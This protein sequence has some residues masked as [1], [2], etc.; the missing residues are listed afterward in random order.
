MTAKRQPPRHL[1]SRRMVRRS[2]D[3]NVFLSKKWGPWSFTITRWA[4][5]Q[6]RPIEARIVVG[7]EVIDWRWFVHEATALRWLEKSIRAQYE[8]LR[9]LVEDY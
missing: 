2:R 6:K 9:Y 7:A 4:N 5:H 3:G 8:S 1:F